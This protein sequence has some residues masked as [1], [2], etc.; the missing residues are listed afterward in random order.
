MPSALTRPARILR[1]LPEVAGD[2]W[3]VSSVGATRLEHVRLFLASLYMLAAWHVPFAPEPRFTATI[4]LGERR[5]RLEVAQFFDVACAWSVLRGGEYDVG[6]PEHAGVI[7]DLGSNIG[8]S[9]LAFRERY[10]DA[11][12]YGFEP[13]P[14]A[15]A[16]LQRNVGDDPNVEIRQVAVGARDGTADFYAAKDSWASSLQPTRDRHDRVQV[17]TRSLASIL[18]ELGV[19]RVDLLKVD[20]EGA[21]GDIFDAFAPLPR[22]RWIVGELHLELL[23]YDHQ[24]FFDRYLRGYEIDAHASEGFATFSAQPQAALSSPRG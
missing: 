24:E 10:P 13:D 21:E 3:K 14:K 19:D 1:R 2:A 16:L 8:V 22:V 9:I 15:F 18:D 20:V 12:I 6:F 23:G 11:R 5:R 4:A 17:T 7:V